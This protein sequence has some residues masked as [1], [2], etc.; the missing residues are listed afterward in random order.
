[1]FRITQQRIIDSSESSLYFA[2]HQLRSCNHESDLNIYSDMDEPESFDP[3]MFIR[4]VPDLPELS[5]DLRPTI[6]PKE[7]KSTKSVTLVLDL[8]GKRIS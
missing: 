1:M 5:S 2:I 3:H 8:D 6:L 4:N 7:K